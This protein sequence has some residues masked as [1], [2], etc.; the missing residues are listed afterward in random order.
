MSNTV[1]KR[2]IV[3]EIAN[4]TGL[5][6]TEVK[7]IIEA[8]IEEISSILEANQTFEIRGFGT[9]YPKKRKPR[10]ARNIHTGEVVPLRE[11][12]VPLF[13]YSGN[14]KDKINKALLGESPVTNVF[15]G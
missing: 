4:Q 15:D 3:I 6:Q 5:T 7:D 2:E 14:L 8:F 1:T 9:F 10:P 12:M 11:R 13:R